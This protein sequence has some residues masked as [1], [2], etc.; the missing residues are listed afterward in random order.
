[1]RSALLILSL[2]TLCMHESPALADDRASRILNEVDDLWRGKSSHALATLKVQTEH[3][4]RTMTLELWSKGKEKSLTKVL[5]PLREKGT[6]TLKSGHHIYTYLPKTGRT[7]R[8][9]SGMMM[10]SWMGSHLT[11]DD[12]VKESR[13]EE[14]YHARITFEGERDGKNIIEFTLMPKEDAA[15]VWGKIILEVEAKRHL[16]VREIFYDED[17]QITRTFTF[18]G[19]KKLAGRVRPSILH[20]SPADKPREYTEFV[21]EKL[22]LNL[23]LEDRFFSKAALK[24]HQR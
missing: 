16:P 2:L 10:S 1:M 9:S 14:D 3:Y 23:P 17:M 19:L 6:I 4:T 24:R 8:L 13:L 7:I 20:I 18:T 22:T 12:L 21:F 15:V 11:N 5:T